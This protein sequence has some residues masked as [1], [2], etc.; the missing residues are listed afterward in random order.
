MTQIRDGD[1]WE[2]FEERVKQR[3]PKSVR[4]TKVEGRATQEIVNEGKVRAEDKER[5]DNADEAADMGAT[6]SQGKLHIFAEIFS[7]RHARY[8][9][10]MARI[11]RFIVELKKEEK[12]LKQEEEKA[13][14]P[15]EKK[16]ARKEQVAQT[17]SYPNPEEGERL[18]MHNTKGQWCKDKEEQ[19]YV[20]GVQSVI[21]N[22]AWKKEKEE[23]GGV[24]WIELYAIYMMHGGR[25]REESERSRPAE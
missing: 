11:Q 16:E 15:F 9:S 5:N 7:W 19:R 3:G 22:L 4:T 25:D 1:L 10:R 24:T 21:S 14:D 12:K 23:E 18:R 17:L 8:R 2:L 13:K 6:T 20:Q